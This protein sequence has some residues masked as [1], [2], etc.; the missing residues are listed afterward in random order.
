MPH[1]TLFVGNWQAFNMAKTGL[2][3]PVVSAGLCAF[4]VK[5][6]GCDEGHAM[7][8]GGR[9][10]RAFQSSNAGRVTVTFSAREARKRWQDTAP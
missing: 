9:S 6:P 7:S 10:A 5:P 1:Y 3:C 4:V 8:S 2:P